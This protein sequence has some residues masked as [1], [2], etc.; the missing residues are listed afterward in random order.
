MDVL[1]SFP[2]EAVFVLGLEQSVGEDRGREMPCMPSR[3]NRTHRSIETDKEG[4]TV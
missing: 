2:K 1:E 4:S 3:E